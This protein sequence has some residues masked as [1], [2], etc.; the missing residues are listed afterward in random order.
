[1]DPVIT[2]AAIGAGANLLGGAIGAS[3]SRH[4]ADVQRDLGL[5]AF[6]HDTAW[7]LRD[8][9]TQREFAQHGVRWRVEDAA[10]AGLHPLFALGGNTATFT[11]SASSVNFGD[12]GSGARARASEQMGQALSQAGQH[13][14]RAVAAQETQDQQNFRMAQLDAMRASSERDY[15][16]AS[17]HAA[18][19]ALLNQQRVAPFPDMGDASGW[20]G[21]SSGRGSG[22]LVHQGVPEQGR[23]GPFFDRRQI[24][25][26]R[27]M[28]A[29]SLDASQ[30]AGSSPHWK[31]YRFKDEDG[32]Q[33]LIDLPSGSSASEAWE[34]MAESKTVLLM[35]LNRNIKKY[36]QAWFV[37]F[38]RDFGALIPGLQ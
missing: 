6:A 11:P 37:E 12:M 23:A 25:P 10:A 2:G 31:V 17:R 21:G 38:I 9:A 8:E 18:E 16:L 36:G 7:R 19:A 33:M 13:V 20:I 30:E 24:E 5:H 22:D 14:A 27:I 15:A 29:N 26:S 35:V 34:S 28:S 4:A 1:M 3:G 32:R